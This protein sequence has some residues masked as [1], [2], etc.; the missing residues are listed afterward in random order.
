MALQPTP[1]GSLHTGDGTHK[2]DGKR[3]TMLKN[4]DETLKPSGQPGGVQGG[5]FGSTQV[6]TF[7]VLT[8]GWQPSGRSTIA[9]CSFEKGIGTRALGAVS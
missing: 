6:N 1:S 9:L 4:R 7:Q 5:G 8:D 2:A 3:G